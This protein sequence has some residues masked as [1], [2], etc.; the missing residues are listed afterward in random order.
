MSDG[1]DDHAG[2]WEAAMVPNYGTPALLLASGDGSRV[3]DADGNTYV[4]LLAGVAVNALGHRHP[5][6]VEAIRGQMEHILHT[7]NLYANEPAL[8]LAERLQR[9]THGHKALLV[10]SGT[11]ANEAALKLCRK[12]AHATDRPQGVV[13]VFEGSF[14]GRTTGA[15]ALTGQPKHR[16]GFDPLPGQ[17]VTVPF[18]DADALEQAFDAHEVV[19]VFA[20]FVQGEGGV[21]PMTPDLAETLGTLCKQNDALL[22]ADEVQTGIGR[23]GRFWA[24]EHFNV[25]PDVVTV[26]KGL[27]GGMPIGACL[28]RDDLAGLLGPGSHGCTFGGN[29]VAAA[30]ANA[31]LDTIDA[32]FLDR[33][34]ALSKRA[35][36]ILEGAG[37]PVRGAGLLLGCRLEE[38]VAPKVLAAMRDAGYLVGQAGKA[39]VRIAPPLTI[40]EKDLE[41][42]VKALA[43]ALQDATVETVA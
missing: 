21:V 11:E 7:S 42:G 2:R 29:P 4:D 14:H 34:E 23:T 41:A 15:L 43:E 13:V 25:I 22:V 12:H 39:V 36:A 8:R 30:A 18:N 32:A 19:A 37:R 10:N 33:V 31:V 3:Q 24:H 17:I 40:D 1:P 9:R 5:A 27:G 6:V 28:V 16:E 38:P 35:I 20:E 26:A